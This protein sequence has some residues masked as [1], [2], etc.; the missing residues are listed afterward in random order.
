MLLIDTPELADEATALANNVRQARE[1]A[2]FGLLTRQLKQFNYRLQFVAEDQAELK[3][4]LQKLLQLVIEDRVAEQ[5]DIIG[6]VFP[7]QQLLYM[8]FR[9]LNDG[10]AI[11]QHEHHMA[12]YG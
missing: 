8:Q 1:A 11:A 10:F 7:A 5:A 6:A 4:A 2:T 3:A 9:P 12:R